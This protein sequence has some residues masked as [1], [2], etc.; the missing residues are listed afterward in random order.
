MARRYQI[1]QPATQDAA[2]Q[3]Q[4]GSVQ[5]QLTRL[6]QDVA[7]YTPGNASSWDPA[8]GPPRTLQEALDRIAAR[9]ASSGTGP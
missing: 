8:L 1:E 2:A 3:H 4:W 5:R 7:T 6:S 9:I